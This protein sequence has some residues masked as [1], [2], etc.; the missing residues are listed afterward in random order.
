MD[1]PTRHVQILECHDE[2]LQ[3]ISVMTTHTE[4]KTHKTLISVSPQ[5]K[6]TIYH[7][8][9]CIYLCLRLSRQ[10]LICH[11]TA[12]RS[13]DN[14]DIKRIRKIALLNATTTQKHLYVQ[15]GRTVFQFY[16]KTKSIERAIK[17]TWPSIHF[18]HLT[19]LFSLQYLSR[20]SASGNLQHEI[21]K[22]ISMQ[23]CQ[24]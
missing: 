7:F 16:K 17:R 20:S 18:F 24:M 2:P 21:S 4:K 11:T 15:I 10:A 22:V 23:P 14:D 12:Y 9:H 5:V 13:N 3:G 19:S 8:L 6:T 1:C